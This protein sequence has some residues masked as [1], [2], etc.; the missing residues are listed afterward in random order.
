MN[1]QTFEISD[2]FLAQL[3]EDLV[4]RHVGRGMA[5]LEDHPQLLTSFDP[6]QK[7]AGRF[8]GYVAQWVDIGFQRPNLIGEMVSRFVKLVRSRLPVHD[9]M[10]LRLAEGMVAMA[11]KV[12]HQVPQAIAAS[13]ILHPTCLESSILTVISEDDQFLLRS[14]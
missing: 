4:C 5:C 1:R 8:V 13:M 10:Y 12:V 11:E 3:K 6:E 14:G 9:Y 2:E 7:N